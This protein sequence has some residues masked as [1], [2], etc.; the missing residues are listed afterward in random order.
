MHARTH[1]HTTVLRPFFRDHPGE[2]VPKENFLTLWCKGRLTEAHTP[3]IRIGATL[4]GLSSAHLRH[5]PFFTGRMPFLPPNQ[6][7]QST[8]GNILK[9]CQTMQSLTSVHVANDRQCSTLSAVAHR[10]S[11]R[12]ICSGFT[13]LML[14]LLNGWI[15]WY[16]ACKCT[17]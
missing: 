15:W 7:C 8:E 2:P 11:C 6:Q 17:R 16:M 3:T 5:P 14:L 9:L 10:S 13:W 4:S 12:V 1:A